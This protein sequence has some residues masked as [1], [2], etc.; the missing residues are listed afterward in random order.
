MIGPVKLATGYNPD[1]N[2]RNNG[3][4]MM[5]SDQARGQLQPAGTLVL[6]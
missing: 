4:A 2:G 1:N 3:W 6:I 5:K